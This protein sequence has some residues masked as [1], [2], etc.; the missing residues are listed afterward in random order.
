MTVRMV[1]HV[2]SAPISTS[3]SSWPPSASSAHAVTGGRGIGDA[4]RA[5]RW[6]PPRGLVAQGTGQVG[7]GDE[8]G[9]EAAIGQRVGE[10]A[11]HEHFPVQ[12]PPFDVL[13]GKR[14]A[15]HAI[16][17]VE[18]GQGVQAVG[19]QPEER[20]EA[21]FLGA[22]FEHRDRETRLQ[23]RECRGVPGD[24]AADHDCV[25]HHT[26]RPTLSR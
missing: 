26:F 6:R 9:A 19:V 11:P 15:C 8:P 7:P 16:E 21:V 5:G 10:R 17:Q 14:H 3:P 25:A 18:R 4:H 23:Q 24:P 12:F 2:P 1:D 22:L 20:A 13:D